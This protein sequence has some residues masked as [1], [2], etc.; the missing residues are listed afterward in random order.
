MRP[1]F[2]SRSES[3]IYFTEEASPMLIKINN[4]IINTAN[5][6]SAYF[7]PAADNREAHLVLKCVNSVESSKA[8]GDD[9]LKG[10]EA[11]KVWET[12][13]KEARDITRSKDADTKFEQSEFFR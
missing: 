1:L 4:T 12:L 6:V 13:C 8:I 2:R 11:T 9:V 5:I 10:D 3:A 7:T